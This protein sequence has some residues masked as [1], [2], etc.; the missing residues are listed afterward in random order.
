MQRFTFILTVTP[1][2]NCPEY[3]VPYMLKDKL[4]GEIE[5]LVKQ[6][7]LKAVQFP[8]CAAQVVPVLKK[9]VSAWFCGDYKQ[10]VNQAANLDTYRL[11]R[12]EDLFASFTGGMIF[13]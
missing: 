3:P 11:P 6:E 1:S 13:Y 12:I 7:I 2:H 8:E 4:G 5:C 10:T 9:N